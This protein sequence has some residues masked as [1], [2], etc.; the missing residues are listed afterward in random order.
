MTSVYIHTSLRKL[1]FPGCLNFS[2][3]IE[4]S[5]LCLS[6]LVSLCSYASCVWVSANGFGCMAACHCM[7]MTTKL[8][9]VALFFSVTCPST[10]IT[11]SSHPSPLIL[12]VD[13]S[14]HR[15]ITLNSILSCDSE[16]IGICYHSMMISGKNEII[17]TSPI[18][19][20]SLHRVCPQLMWRNYEWS[21]HLHVV[22]E[23]PKLE[24]PSVIR[25][26]IHDTMD[27]PGWSSVAV[28]RTTHGNKKL[29]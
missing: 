20:I 7:V 28:W 11:S 9:N 22:R 1:K 16:Q 2:E 23:L 10:L 5:Y 19:D 26:T 25:R 27:G 12:C 13:V 21:Y 14:I 15:V 29:P 3:I 17:A 18:A 8:C 4:Y 24:G 6:L